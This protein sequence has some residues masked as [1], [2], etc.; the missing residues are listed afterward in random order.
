MD[1]LRTL[2]RPPQVILTTAFHEYALESYELNVVDYLLKPFG[3]PRFLAAV[4]K[5]VLTSPESTVLS[6][7]SSET[8]PFHF[9]NENKRM[10]KVYHDE[11]VYVESLKEYV[12][13]F[14]ANGQAV[15]TRSQLGEFEKMVGAGGFLRIHRSYLVALSQIQAYTAT[16][17][18]VGGKSLPIGRAT[19]DFRLWTS[20]FR[21]WTA[22]CQLT[23]YSPH[24][25][26]T[27]AGGTP[28][29]R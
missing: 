10:V 28:G 13:I 8:R 21:L 3:L 5:L 26:H 22:D 2:D 12:R 19:S 29:H 20:D 1:L 6:P 7:Q 17:V 4:N 9:F 18:E 23:S 24:T 25:F 27:G 14:L 11:I 16:T 15:V